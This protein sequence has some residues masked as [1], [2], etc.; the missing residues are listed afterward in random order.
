MSGNNRIISIVNYGGDESER[1]AAALAAALGEAGFRILTDNAK[2]AELVIV[3]GGDGSLLW[4]LQRFGFP[5]VPFVGFNTGHLGFFQ[6]LN[7]SDMEGFVA[8]YLKGDYEKQ[9]FRTV[10]G[11]IE[12][13]GTPEKKTV[14]GLNELLIITA[15]SRLAHFDI[16]IGEHLVEKFHGDGVVISTPAGSTAYN[17]ALGGAIIDPRLDLLQ[18]TPI[19]PLNTTAYRSFTSGIALPPGLPVRVFP[20]EGSETIVACDGN[21]EELKGVR[22]IEAGLSE[23]SVTLLR[24]KGHDFWEIVKQKLLSL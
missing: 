12:F 16:Y 14:R 11:L 13:T 23:K 17:Y 8:Q 7:E 24:F 19:A 21:E 2:G 3:A 15:G 22:S 4:T 5:D 20:A 6:E 18:L 1:L 9:S 10:S